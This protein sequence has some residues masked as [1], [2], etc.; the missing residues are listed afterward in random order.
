MYMFIK[1]AARNYQP[2]PSDI[3][4]YGDNCGDLKISIFPKLDFEK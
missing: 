4:L 2:D 1:A 3:L